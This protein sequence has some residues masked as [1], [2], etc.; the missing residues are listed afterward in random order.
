MN[1]E[2]L[3]PALD[4]DGLPDDWES[5]T[6]DWESL[7][8]IGQLIR[9]QQDGH[10]WLLGDLA[11]KVERAYGD[12]SLEKFSSDIGIDRVKTLR[13]YHRVARFY[14]SAARAEFPA[15]SWSHYREAM[16]SGDVDKAMAKLEEAEGNNWPVA[17]LGRKIG[18][19][20][21][22]KKV[23]DKEGLSV[24]LYQFITQTVSQMDVTK[25][26]HVVISEL[27]EEEPNGAN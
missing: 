24:E 23:F 16:R 8:A 15:L 20:T 25:K 26:I 27:V 22:W 17:E 10:R 14:P 18:G 11:A 21:H 3:A 4:L 7:T 9:Q 19:R 12:K 2:E 5:L 13:D 1:S 6:D